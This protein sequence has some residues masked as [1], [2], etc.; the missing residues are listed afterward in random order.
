MNNGNPIERLINDGTGTYQLTRKTA[1]E[2]Y[3]AAKKV[4][5][6]G[7]TCWTRKRWKGTK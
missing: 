6:P 3:R 4:K 5:L 2:A 7:I 1:G